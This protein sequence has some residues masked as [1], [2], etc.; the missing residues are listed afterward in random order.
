[1]NCPNCGA[2]LTTLPMHGIEVDECPNCHGLWFDPSEF[3]ETIDLAEPAIRWLDFDV[4]TDADALEVEWS[5]RVCPICKKGLATISYQSTG[6]TIDYCIDHHGIWLDKG[7]FENIIS[8]LEAEAY[9]RSADDYVKQTLEEAK[10]IVTGPDSFVSE[11]KDFK[12]VAWLLQL[13]IL[14]ENPRLDQ[15]LSALQA[16][17]PFK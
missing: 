5:T 13:R 4:W 14:I 6:E 17:S 1:M 16:S 12:T 8:A 10:E 9:S 11:W 2:T 7:E 15:A 3:E